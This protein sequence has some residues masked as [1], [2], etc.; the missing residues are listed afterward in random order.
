MYICLYSF[1]IRMKYIISSFLLLFKNWHKNILLFSDKLS[2]L[3]FSSFL[4]GVLACLISK[5]VCFKVLHS[6][7]SLTSIIYNYFFYYRY[8]IL[9]K[10]IKGKRLVYNRRSNMCFQLKM[11]CSSFLFIKLFGN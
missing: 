7:V 5:S 4:F 1:F 10:C 8:C 6:S 3:S 9:Y 11:R 2:I